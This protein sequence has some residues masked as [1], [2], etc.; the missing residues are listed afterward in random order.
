MTIRYLSATELLYLN[1]YLSQREKMPF[2]I[3]SLSALEE[4]IA[5][6]Q[7]KLEGDYEP[8]PDVWQKAAALVDSCV[9]QKP[10]VKM[11]ALTGFFGA[12]LFL[13]LNGQVLRSAPED[14][15]Y[16]GSM[17]LQ[18]ETLPQIAAWLTNRATAQETI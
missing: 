6:P 17:A 5:R 1:A 4:A 11:N 9:K 14:L 10:F 2:G 3:K 18:Q 7:L 8:F 12:D 13:R 16:I 15:E